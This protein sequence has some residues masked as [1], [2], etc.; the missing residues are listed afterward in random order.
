MLNVILEYG[1]RWFEAQNLMDD[2]YI[3]DMLANRPGGTG[4]LQERTP[5]L[6]PTSFL[7]ISGIFWYLCGIFM[8]YSGNDDYIFDMIANRPGGTGSLQESPRLSL[9][10][11]S[12]TFLLFSV[13]FWCFPGFWC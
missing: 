6:L 5:P 3:A 4:S 1:G 7:E 12:W 11:A 8:V 13:F 2:D 10:L 9:P